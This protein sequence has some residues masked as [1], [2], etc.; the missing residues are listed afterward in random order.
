MDT[1]A[2]GK[3]G[4]PGVP[5]SRR[6]CIAHYLGAMPYELGLKLQEAAKA[7]RADRVINDVL[8]LLQ[9]PAVF[10]I[11]RF[12]GENDITVSPDVL[13]RE[14][15]AVFHTNRGGGITYHGPGQLVVYPV[16]SLRENS[17]GVREYIHKLEGTI[18]RLLLHFGISGYR[19]PENPG[20]W[21]NGRKICSLGIHI[22]RGVTMH[23]FALNV[24]PNLGHFDYINACGLKGKVMTSLS[25]VLGRPVEV[26]AIIGPLLDAFSAVFGVEVK[27]GDNRCLPTLDGQSG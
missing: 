12:K 22:S 19:D 20:V 16:L 15:I 26:E 3:P 25:R 18:I 8:L 4:Q 11:G 17:L 5:A 6:A 23:G 10:T 13:E 27:Q 7:A 24:D 2:D 14:G 21:V 9:H 1:L